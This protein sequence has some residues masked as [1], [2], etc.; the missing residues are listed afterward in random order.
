MERPKDMRQI[1][2]VRKIGGLCGFAGQAVEG[3]Q[4]TATVH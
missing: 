2:N 3:E 4:R 1:Y